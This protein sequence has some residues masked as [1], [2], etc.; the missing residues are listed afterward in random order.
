[1]DERRRKALEQKA[2]KDIPVVDNL[3]A[4]E[5]F[6][7]EASF[8]SFAPDVVTITLTAFRWDHSA[9][10][11]AQRRVVVGRLVMPIPG[12][13]HLAAGLADYLRRSGLEPTPIAQETKLQ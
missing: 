6:A 7:S 12:V 9:N 3:F 13:R 10:P 8:F 2:L 11:A 1:M 5:V 4:P